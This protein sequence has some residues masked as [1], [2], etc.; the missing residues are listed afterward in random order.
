M[1]QRTIFHYKHE[2]ENMDSVGVKNGGKLLEEVAKRC[3]NKPDLFV[4]VE[5]GQ[6]TLKC[7]QST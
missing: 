7:L 3:T 1:N 6:K 4:E 2:L 5:D